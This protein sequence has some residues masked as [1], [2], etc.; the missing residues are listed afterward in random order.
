MGH[1]RQEKS[2]TERTGYGGQASAAGDDIDHV[3]KK[4]GFHHAQTS[5]GAMGIA[6]HWV[7]LAGTMAPI[8]IGEL[9]EDAGKRWK[10]TRLAAVAT[11]VAYEGLYTLHEMQRR[12]EQRAK[13][14]ECEARNA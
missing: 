14:A 1:Q 11:A 12:K 9:I 8:I 6:G 2:W 5:L 4:Q 13:L 7:G 10:A 3:L